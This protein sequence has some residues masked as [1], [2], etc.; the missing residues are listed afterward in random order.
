MT[1]VPP[2]TH[3]NITRVPLP[4]TIAHHHKKYIYTCISSLSVGY[5]YC[6]QKQE[7]LKSCKLKNAREE[8]REIL[9]MV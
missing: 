7:R 1:R 3:I 2:T 6:T 9:L 5:H 4:L 8:Q